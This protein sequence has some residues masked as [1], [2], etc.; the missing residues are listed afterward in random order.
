MEKGPKKA[1]NAHPH[2]ILVEQRLSMKIK[3]CI[4]VLIGSQS[5]EIFPLEKE[6][7][8]AKCDSLTA[9]E[10]DSYDAFC[11]IMIKTKQ[12]RKCYKIL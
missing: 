5:E 8:S 11:Q 3:R 9:Y 7:Q 6:A 4:L 1:K 2:S 10:R 12:L